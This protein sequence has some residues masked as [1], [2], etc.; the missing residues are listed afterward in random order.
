MLWFPWYHPASA[1]YWWVIIASTGLPAVEHRDTA[2]PLSVRIFPC[3]SLH[4]PF[5]L[6]DK[7]ANPN[8]VI[9]VWD[10]QWIIQFL[11]FTHGLSWVNKLS[12]FCKADKYISRC[13][14]GMGYI[15]VV[16]RCETYR[17][18]GQ[19]SFAGEAAGWKASEAWLPDLELGQQ[20]APKLSIR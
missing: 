20:E 13:F 12:C 7:E 18:K 14:L 17:E 3:L 19:E 8:L 6:E 11:I 5:F 1:C 10:M 2:W 4:L 16:E 15:A 9:K